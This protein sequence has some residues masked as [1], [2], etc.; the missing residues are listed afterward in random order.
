MAALEKQD[1]RATLADQPRSGD[2]ARRTTADYNV[3]VTPL[4]VGHLVVRP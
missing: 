2:T 4:Y 1:A 3:I